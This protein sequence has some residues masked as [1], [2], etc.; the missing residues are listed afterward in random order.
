LPKQVVEGMIEGLGF[1]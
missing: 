1:V